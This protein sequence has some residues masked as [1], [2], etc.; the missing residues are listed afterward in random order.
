MKHSIF[1]LFISLFIFF[2]IG[3]FGDINI[4]QKTL[5]TFVNDR[6]LVMDVWYPTKEGI[7]SQREEG[8]WLFPPIVYDASIPK[9]KKLPLILI[10]HG[11]GGERKEQLW[12]AEK[13][14]MAGYLVASVDHFGNTWKDPS[15]Q[16]MI[17]MWNRP[18]DISSA[19][20]YLTGDSPFA[21]TID[22]KQVGFV[23]FSVGG[24]TGLWLA[25][26]E[27]K[28]PEVMHLFSEGQKAEL[29]NSI[30]FTKAMKSYQDDR[31][32]QF[33]LLAPR[34]SEFSQSSLS[35]IK[36]PLLV[37]Y[38]T[39]DKVLPPEEHAKLI[40]ASNL[41]T[42]ELPH[43]SHFVFLNQVT[44]EGKKALSPQLWESSSERALFHNQIAET[45]IIFLKEPIH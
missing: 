10:S 17:Q 37:I 12:L 44:E 21:H 29:V 4:G 3:V 16:G 19:L 13:L 15:P 45:V 42:L 40:E 23:G 32:S 43:A 14:A 34:V 9:D 31:I 36:K 11:Y 24:M 20:D 8:V 35:K 18:E 39:E 28:S 22:T 7:P 26:A 38:G 6:P 2:S 5:C 41:E 30:D 1:K 27:V 25:G 33:V